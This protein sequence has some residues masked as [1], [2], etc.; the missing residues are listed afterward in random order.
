MD[1]V[2]CSVYVRLRIFLD[3]AFCLW[4]SDW[5][6]VR[7]LRVRRLKIFVAVPRRIQNGG[8]CSGPA[9]SKNQEASE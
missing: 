2:Y 3:L 5:L 4:P 8:S 9:S 7:H 1:Y 6:R